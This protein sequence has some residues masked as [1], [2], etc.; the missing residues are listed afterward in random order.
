MSEESMFFDNIDGDREYNAEQYSEYFR[1]I[2]TTGVLGTGDNLK[3]YATGDDRIARVKVG[4]AWIEGRM[5][6]L[7]D[8]ELELPLDEAHGT[9]DRVDRIVLR[10]DTTSPVRTIEAS[11]KTGE[12]ATTPI[13]PDLTREG[14]VYEISLAQIKIPH[15]T[16][17]IIDGNI[18]DERKDPSVCGVA[19]Y[20]LHDEE[21]KDLNELQEKLNTHTAD[22]GNPHSVTKAQ[23][24]LGSVTDNKQATKTEF[25]SHVA[26]KV[27]SG[28]LHGFRV[29]SDK[30]LEFYDGS[31]WKAANWQVPDPNTWEGTQNIVRA[32][33][34]RDFFDIGDQLE[35]NY[36]GK[37]I[38]WEVIGIDVDTPYNTSF[39]H[40]MT[41]QSKDILH[42][43]Q[44][45]AEEPNNPDS[46]RQKYGNNRY[47]YSAV[48]QWLNSNESTFHWVSRHQ[49]D[50][51]PNK[52]LDYYNGSGFLYRLDPE[53]VAVLGTV[54][55]KVAKPEVDG[56][57]QDTFNDKV[58]LLSSV[59][60]GFESEGTTTG[61]AV[62]PYYSGIDDSGRIK[63]LDGT[64]RW[65]L[66]SP[67]VSNA[68]NVRDVYSDG[69]R[70]HGTAYYSTD[71]LSPACV[72]I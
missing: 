67:Y 71:G 51:K 70:S 28:E 57:G 45:D 23:V 66:R 53:L 30:E 54:T 21:E 72:I 69:S 26:K 22:R 8:S 27:S 17:V 34:A 61:E 43:L 64:N 20:P 35:S 31:N 3:V 39:T 40:S 60:V 48:K 62:Y 12:P 7:K 13:P 11:V 44:F 50:A 10:L 49:Y 65:W 4:Y 32:G 24:G 63:Q 29:N 41:I 56:G 38:T 59:E 42:Y 46:N 1:Q 33:R 2:L 37:V 36:D 9:Y 58:F 47:I 25:D 18:T 16:T 55:K 68:N 6:H 14:K 52:T 15:N 19:H 5:Y